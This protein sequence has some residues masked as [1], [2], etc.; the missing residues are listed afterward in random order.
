GYGGWYEASN[1]GNIRSWV[2]RRS[3]QYRANWERLNEPRPLKLVRDRRHWYVNLC[4]EGERKKEHVA[5]LVLRTVAGEPQ[6]GE[7]ALHYDDNPANNYLENLYWA[8]GQQNSDDA[9]RNDRTPRG[10]SHG[11][12]K[13]TEAEVK[14]IRKLSDSYSRDELARKFGV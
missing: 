13:L 10:E 8:T 14:E 3:N 1:R 5:R 11:C 9:V 7:M 2:K 12:V 6:T 4:L